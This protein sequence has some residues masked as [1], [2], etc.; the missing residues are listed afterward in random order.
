MD[1]DRYHCE[2]VEGCDNAPFWRTEW[3]WCCDRHI[4]I[5]AIEFCRATPPLMAPRGG[6]PICGKYVDVLCALQVGESGII[7]PR[8]GECAKLLVAA[9]RKQ[10]GEERIEV[11]ELADGLKDAKGGELGQRF[12]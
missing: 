8:C 4:P 10:Y 11:I 5:D 2:Q 1:T 7:R 3:G 12:S 9:W 6:P